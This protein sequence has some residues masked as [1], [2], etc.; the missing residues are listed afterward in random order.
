MLFSKRDSD[1]TTVQYLTVI[2]EDDDC[3]NRVSYCSP[4]QQQQGR[5]LHHNGGVWQSSKGQEADGRRRNVRGWLLVTG[6]RGKF[7][8]KL[9]D[10]R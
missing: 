9:Q 7:D 4:Q 5:R 2:V 6:G 8:G 1:P 10:C 3:Y